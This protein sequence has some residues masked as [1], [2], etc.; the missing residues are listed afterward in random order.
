M[1]GHDGLDCAVVRIDPQRDILEFSGASIDLFSIT[2]DGAVSRHRGSHK[3]L[4]YSL[5]QGVEQIASTSIPMGDNAFLIT[6][7]G[8][9]TQVGEATR[10]VMGTR[11]FEAGLKEAGTN[12]PARLIHTAAR[13][14]KA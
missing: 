4:G 1:R 14:L 8:L 6:T 12:E 7:D 3:T 10:R 5:D 11:R 9:L 13:V 2:P